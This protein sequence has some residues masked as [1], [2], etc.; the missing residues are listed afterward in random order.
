MRPMLSIV[1][2]PVPPSLPGKSKLRS[3][4]DFELRE[5][6][7][8]CVIQEHLPNK[9]NPTLIK[10]YQVIE[11]EIDI[12]FQTLDETTGAGHIPPTQDVDELWVRL[13]FQT[14]TEIESRF[15]CLFESTSGVPRYYML[16]YTF[17]EAWFALFLRKD[18]L[19]YHNSAPVMPKKNVKLFDSMGINDHVE[20][21]TP[22]VKS[23]NIAEF[24]SWHHLSNQ[25]LKRLNRFSS[26]EG[27]K[28]S[29]KWPNLQI[30]PPRTLANRERY[31]SACCKLVSE[32][33]P[34][35]KVLFLT[36]PTGRGK[37]TLLHEFRIIC[38]SLQHL[39]TVTIDFKN[40]LSSQQLLLNLIEQIAPGPLSENIA[41]TTD[42]RTRL[43][44]CFFDAIQKSS[45]SIVIVFD[46]FE[47]ADNSCV[48][49][50]RDCLMA[51]LHRLDIR[52]VI[53]GQK[54][55]EKPENWEA[56]YL[57]LP[58]ELISDVET[59]KDYRDRNGIQVSN[60]ELTQWVLSHK[61]EPSIALAQDWWTPDEYFT[62]RMGGHQCQRL[63]NAR[64]EHSPNSSKEM[65]SIWS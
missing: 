51:N 62:I 49:W 7:H 54:I 28:V 17:W 22:Y 64:S 47:Y 26:S 41:T 59:W 27:E 50:V 37:S 8:S 3:F 39:Q 12:V 15:P 18:L 6:G 1:N 45:R 53:A 25:I 55:P 57:E 60:E 29:V 2:D 40:K 30:E 63:S 13:D 19:I 14:K 24:Q 32:S 23:Y 52:V 21:I 61:G 46:S 10:L 16:S 38:Q 48:Y 36:G 58:L 65:P 43:S 20:L 11:Q 33:D 4:L 31:I 35:V 9:G 42:R 5:F 56:T 44:G 34:L